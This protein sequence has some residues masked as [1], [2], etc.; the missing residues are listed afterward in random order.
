MS[1]DRTASSHHLERA[2]AVDMREIAAN[3]IQEL[4]HQQRA[5]Q[6]ERAYKE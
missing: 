1:S 2:L 6:S 3:Y 5:A 4:D